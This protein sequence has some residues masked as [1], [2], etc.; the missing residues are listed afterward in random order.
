[1]IDEPGHRHW[2]REP[3]LHFILI[4]AVLFVL[5]EWRG[6]GVGSARIVI[7][8]GQIDA[9]ALAFERTWQRPPSE[10]ELKGQIDEY[11]REEI[12]TREAMALGLDRDDTIIRRRLRQKLEFLAED[13]ADAAPPTDAELQAW[14]ETHPESYTVDPE[15]SFRQV[16]LSPDRH[17]AGV[18]VAAV[19]LRETLAR[20]GADAPIDTLG[21]AVMLP[22]ELLRTTRADVARQFGDEFADALLATEI[23]RWAGPVRSGYGLHVVF[24]R[25]RAPGRLPPLADVRPHVERDFTTDRRRRQLQAMYDDLLARHRVVIERREPAPEPAA[26]AAPDL[27]GGRP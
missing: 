6:G 12:A 23:G 27:R 14:L 21:D 8:S 16:F 25:D 1:M 9:L 18:E 26:P 15:L 13:T 5:F 7:T 17:G 24:V 20:H 11:V 3:L 22:P 19:S 4:G 10:E 2:W